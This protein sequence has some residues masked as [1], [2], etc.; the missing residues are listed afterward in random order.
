[1]T[2]KRA[3]IVAAA[4]EY[5]DAP[6]LHQGRT[7]QGI[8]C[9]GLIKVVGDAVGYSLVIPENYSRAPNGLALLRGT[10]ERLFKPE[11]QG[12]NFIKEGDVVLSWGWQDGVPQHFSIATTLFS[13][14]AMIHAFERAGK[15][16]E[17]NVQPIWGKRYVATFC[18]PGTE[19]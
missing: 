2:I 8:D 19:E 5:L 17:H 11:R 16:V 14:R 4:R 9:L 10:E 1:M 18:F 3:D 12:F 6:F 13:K 15:V 7:K